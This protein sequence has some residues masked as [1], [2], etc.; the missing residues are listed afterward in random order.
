[1]WKECGKNGKQNKTPTFVL[2]DKYLCPNHFIDE[3]SI[4]MDVFVYRDAHSSAHLG[5]STMKVIYITPVFL[6]PQDCWNFQLFLFLKSEYQS[7]M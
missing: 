6:R 3:P 7:L 4:T 2:R 1:M 5:D